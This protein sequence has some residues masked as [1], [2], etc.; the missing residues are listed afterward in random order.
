MS[1]SE[2]AA[3][4]SAVTSP[5]T[6]PPVTSGSVVVVTVGAGCVELGEGTVDGGSVVLGLGVVL[7][8]V[9]DVLDCVVV[10]AGTDV[11]T[12]SA[13]EEVAT[14]VVTEGLGS[15]EVVVE[16]T[17]VSVVVVLVAVVLGIVRVV[18]GGTLVTAT[19]DTAPDSTAVVVVS[20]SEE[21]ESVD[22]GSAPVKEVLL[23]EGSVDVGSGSLVVVD[24][25]DGSVVV[26]DD[27]VV[28]DD[29]VTFVVSGS[30]VRFVDP[31]DTKPNPCVVPY[32]VNRTMYVPGIASNE[33]RA[34]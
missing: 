9:D 25:G 13:T 29:V 2:R 30:G 22:V 5:S 24:S 21:S 4:S 20:G 11:V 15:D 32:R 23:G 12:G 14:V 10:G 27:E 26:D 16:S 28:E 31:H 33:T 6:S 19:V 34:A 7:V 18:D 8:V 17:D 1:I 3:T